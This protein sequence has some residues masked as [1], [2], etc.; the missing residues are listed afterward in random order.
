MWHR[1]SL[2][3]PECELLYGR[4]GKPHS[5]PH[6][7]EENASSLSR[8]LCRVSVNTTPRQ[9]QATSTA[10]CSSR[11]TSRSGCCPA[12]FE[13]WHARCSSPLSPTAAST[14]AHGTPTRQ[15]VARAHTHAHTHTPGHHWG[16]LNVLYTVPI[17]P[18][19]PP[20]RQASRVAAHVQVVPLGVLGRRPRP[21]RHPPRTSLL[22]RPSALSTS[23]HDTWHTHHR[24]L[25]RT[26]AC[27][28]TT[29]HAQRR[30]Q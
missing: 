5:N 8:R 9:W 2:A 13:R 20:P 28:R 11:P 15:H 14:A 4:S 3:D 30:C 23:Q 6:F 16:A 18:P 17:P 26:H 19:P 10:W 27:T 22:P 24:T 21:C 29:A 1:V 12:T 25:A 7:M